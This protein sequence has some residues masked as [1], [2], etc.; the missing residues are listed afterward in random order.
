MKYYYL[1]I[2][3]VIIA[4]G[5]REGRSMRISELNNDQERQIDYLIITSQ[6]EEKAVINKAIIAGAAY[7]IGKTFD[8]VTPM[9]VDDQFVKPV[10]KFGIPGKEP[11]Y[12]RDNESLLGEKIIESVLA[13]IL[14]R[15]NKLAT[16]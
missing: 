11:E 9:A 4:G 2:L 15:L 16:G 3:I 14:N 5:V 10:L 13:V 7:Y 12:A 1:F 6:H 8:E